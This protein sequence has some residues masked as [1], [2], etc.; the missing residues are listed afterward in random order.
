MVDRY[1]PQIYHLRSRSEEVCSFDKAQTHRGFIETANFRRPQ[2]R[3]VYSWIIP[4][5]HGSY[6]IYY[7]DDITPLLVSRAVEENLNLL[8]TSILML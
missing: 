8:K 5:S 6:V 2:P 1:I 3:M 4:F 7:N